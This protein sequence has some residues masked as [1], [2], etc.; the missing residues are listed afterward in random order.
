MS[1]I[2]LLF[3]RDEILN[4]RRGAKR[5][6]ELDAI[7]DQ[8]LQ[9]F[10]EETKT[11]ALEMALLK[12]KN[13]VKKPFFL[14]LKHNPLAIQ[15]GDCVYA[16]KTDVLH[17][18][19]YKGKDGFWHP[20]KEARQYGASCIIA[21]RCHDQDRFFKLNLQTLKKTFLAKTKHVTRFNPRHK[22]S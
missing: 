4:P 6:E 17:T 13:N 2:P 8:H 20:A 19:A 10:S 11:D 3:K 16:A 15:M 1:L 9:N 14:V 5:F 22:R 7:M 18:Y 21:K 12:H